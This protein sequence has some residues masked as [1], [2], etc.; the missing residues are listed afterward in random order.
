MYHYELFISVQQHLKSLYMEYTIFQS[1][2]FQSWFPLDRG[3]QITRNILNK[4]FKVNNLK[5]FLRK[6]YVPPSLAPAISHSV[7][8]VV[9]CLGFSFQCYVLK[10]CWFFTFSVLF[11]AFSVLFR[12]VRLKIENKLNHLFDQLPSTIMQL[13]YFVN[14]L[15]ILEI[16]FIKNWHKNPNGQNHSLD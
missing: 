2:H 16:F 14:F 3:L 5:S 1:L 6:L 9:C 8:S 10:N 12:L 4:E 11:K 15:D 7:W 13:S